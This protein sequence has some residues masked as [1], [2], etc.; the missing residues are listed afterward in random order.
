MKDSM[1]LNKRIMTHHQQEERRLNSALLCSLV[2]IAHVVVCV[3]VL[4]V[5]LGVIVDV[6]IGLDKVLVIA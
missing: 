3:L 4:V 6:L 1:N 5:V 2:Q